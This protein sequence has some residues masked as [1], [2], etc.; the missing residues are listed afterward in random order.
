MHYNR[1]KYSFTICRSTVH[2]YDRSL[3]CTTSKKTSL[4]RPWRVRPSTK[5][6]TTSNKKI[7]KAIDDQTST[8]RPVY[9]APPSHT[10]V[11]KLPLS[12]SI[13]FRQLTTAVPL[14]RASNPALQ[15]SQPVISQEVVAHTRRRPTDLGT[16]CTKVKSP[17]LRLQKRRTRR[18]GIQ[19]VL[20]ESTYPPHAC[21]ISGT[22]SS[23]SCSL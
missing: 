20:R 16:G 19:S 10:L 1:V 9:R 6:D 21:A 12:S 22:A 3:K 15:S 18:Y 11:H 4:W 23:T 2:Q 13:R 7:R 5:T 8:P 17:K 14:S